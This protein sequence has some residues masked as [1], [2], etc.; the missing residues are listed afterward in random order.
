MTLLPLFSWTGGIIG[1]I[2]MFAVFLALVV[3]LFVFMAKG[4]K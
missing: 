3:A 4:K 1:A 2:I